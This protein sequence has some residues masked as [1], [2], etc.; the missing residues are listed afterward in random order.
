M[1]NTQKPWFPKTKG[2]TESQRAALMV[3]AE[4]K[5]AQELRLLMEAKLRGLFKS[6][7]QAALLLEMSAEHAPE[8]MQIRQMINSSQWPEALTASDGMM[9]LLAQ[10]DWKQEIGQRQAQAPEQL[11]LQGILEQLV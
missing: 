4:P 3:D 1:I 6:E 7:R 9:R 8:L 11:G 5:T 2:L 10:V